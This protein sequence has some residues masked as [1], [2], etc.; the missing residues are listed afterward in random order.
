MFTIIWANFK[1]KF[2]DISINISGKAKCFQNPSD[3]EI[4]IFL[5]PLEKL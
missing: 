4:L 1:G 5:V 3:S 2:F